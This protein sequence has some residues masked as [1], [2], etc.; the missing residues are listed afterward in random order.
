MATKIEYYINKLLY[1]YADRRN[2]SLEN[3]GVCQYSL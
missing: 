1:K 2:A 3:K